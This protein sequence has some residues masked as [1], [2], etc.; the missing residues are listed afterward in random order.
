MN[1]A[2]LILEKMAIR[3]GMFTLILTN[4]WFSKI[5]VQL[6]SEKKLTKVYKV[7]KQ[8]VY[9]TVIGDLTETKTQFPSIFFN[10]L[11]T[12]WK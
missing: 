9:Q 11:I 3:Q 6:K 4:Q 12:K 10:K 2:Y 1:P 7:Y 5:F 8:L